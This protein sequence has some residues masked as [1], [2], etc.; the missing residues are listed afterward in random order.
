M[1]IFDAAGLH[2][3]V[4]F[5]LAVIGQN[6]LSIEWGGS[7]MSLFFD[8]LLTEL[9][10]A[11]AETLGEDIV[12]VKPRWGAGTAKMIAKSLAEHVAELSRRDAAFGL[13]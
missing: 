6:D 4:A 3:R 8:A 13:N 10:R 2:G 9:P 1:N 12:E 5:I 11:L 7:D